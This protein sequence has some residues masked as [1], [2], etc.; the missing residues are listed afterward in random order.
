MSSVNHVLRS[1]LQKYQDQGDTV[2][3]YLNSGIKLTGT[4]IDSD[5]GVFLLSSRGEPIIVMLHAV[6]TM[7]PN[8]DSDTR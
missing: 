1:S 8:P 4:I 2:K 6:S 3:V 7:D 5:D